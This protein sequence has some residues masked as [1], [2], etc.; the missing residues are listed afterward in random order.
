M[1]S[2]NAPEATEPTTI[3]PSS[4]EGEPN[5]APQAAA[6]A[7]AASA[8]PIEPKPG[9]VAIRDTD[10]SVQLVRKGDLARVEEEGARPA[11]EAEYYRAETGTPGAIGAGLVGAARSL[12]FGA[13]DPLYIAAG[14]A[15]GGAEGAEDVRRT[16]N[17]MR[18]AHPTADTTGEVAGMIA[19]LLLGDPLQALAGGAE[20]GVGGAGA[21][22][23]GEGLAARTATR[24]AQGAA[25]GAIVGGVAG[26]GAQLSEDAL[27]DHATTAENLMASSARGAIMGGILGGVL[28]T[29][30]G[31]FGDR[32]GGL[33]PAESG[34]EREGERGETVYRSAEMRPTEEASSAKNWLEVKSE[35]GDRGYLGKLADRQA[36]EAT[37][38]KMA[39]YGRLGAT[40]EAIDEETQRLGQRLRDE[41]I[42]TPLATKTDMAQRV[43]ARLSEVGKELG[44]LRKPLDTTSVRPSMT[45]IIDRAQAD[46]IR[47]LEELPQTAGERGVVNEWLSDMVKLSKKGGGLNE[48]GERIPVLDSDPTFEQLY[49]FR[50]R[51]DRE[52]SPQWEKGMV[53]PLPPAF[54]QLQKLRGI[55]EDEYT[56]AATAAAKELG[57]D[58]EAKYA[59]AKGLYGDLKTTQKI[60]AGAVRREASNQAISLTDVI[61]TVGGLAT[62]GPLG[63]LYGAANHVRRTYGNQ[64][65]SHVL[66]KASRLES[67]QRASAQVDGLIKKGVAG[68][69][70]GGEKSAPSIARETPKVTAETAQQIR[71]AARSPEALTAHVAE[72]VGGTGIRDAA[73][74]TAQALATNITRAVTYL[75]SVAPKEGSPVGS[76]LLPQA[77]RAASPTETRRFAEAVQAVD[78][79]LSVVDDRRQGHNSR[80]KV[81][82][83]RE[84]YPKLYA[85]LGL[86]IAQQVA[87]DRPQITEQQQIALSMLFGRPMSA[88]MEPARI[89]AFQATFAQGAGPAKGGKAGGGTRKV[90]KLDRVAGSD[91]SAFDRLE[92]PA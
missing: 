64:I 7:P 54:E 79:P 68:F 84:V 13:S 65:A 88:S 45:A 27:G 42:V 6:P 24:F 78:D 2:T 76:T 41:G 59:M 77:P 49:K 66:D 40:G 1:A 90:R 75:A 91:A 9:M 43:K 34:I 46:I 67:V 39:D 58:F 10:G 23:L 74:K 81:A 62:S 50:R 57:Q 12:T 20:R 14:G 53:K 25:G 63:L 44:E 16:I 35:P 28:H 85:R 19:P 80:D 70:K 72:M 17:L 33:A 92:A 31:A 82:A 86:E 3:L 22:V 71:E 30:V 61:S 36:F 87:E 15:L 32:Y 52:L 51:L 73:P 4:P 89:A 69:L 8:E 21:R 56:R 5:P 11:T 26:A 37:G 38:A 18:D 48:W 83:L 29:S 55:V 47:P 60:L